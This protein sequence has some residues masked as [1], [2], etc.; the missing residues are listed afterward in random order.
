MR[1]RIQ[2]QL[3]TVQTARITQEMA[4]LGRYASKASC[5][6]CQTQR[7]RAG[8]HAL[9]TAQLC[10]KAFNVRGLVTSNLRSAT[11]NCSRLVQ[12]LHPEKPK[13]AHVQ[14]RDYA[15][16]PFGRLAPV[17]DQRI[18]PFAT[19]RP[20]QIAFAF[21][22]SD[23]DRRPSII[24]VQVHRHAISVEIIC[25]SWWRFQCSLPRPELHAS[26]ALWNTAQC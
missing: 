15:S 20:R 6:S 5:A 22:K 16:I 23:P 18:D 2:A 17:I 25:R 9:L 14:C 3:H 1:R 19:S 21:G 26:V 10:A 13:L 8:A 11:I 4:H 7:P 12:T 24:R